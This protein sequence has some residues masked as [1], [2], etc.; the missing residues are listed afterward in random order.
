MTEAI[1]NRR[2]S[3]ACVYVVYVVK[4]IRCYW[5]SFAM[6]ILHCNFKVVKNAIFGS[7][8]YITF[9]EVINGRNKP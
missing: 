1:R 8:T 6:Q 2:E 3:L 4:Q 7:P 9:T 5:N